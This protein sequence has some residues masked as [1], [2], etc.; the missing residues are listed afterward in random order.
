MSKSVLTTIDFDNIDVHDVK[1]LSPSFDGDVLF[2]LP[3]LSMGVPSAMP[4]GCAMDGMDK[5]CDDHLWCTT[6]PQIF[7]MIL[8]FPLNVLFVLVIFSA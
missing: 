8:D 5:M 3:P 2:V 1:Y 7:K 4:Y 6:K